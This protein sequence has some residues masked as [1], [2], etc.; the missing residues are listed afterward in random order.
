M[1]SKNIKKTVVLL[2]EFI[3]VFLMI[4]GIFPLEAGLF[5][6]A[7]LIFYFIFSPTEDSVWVFVASLPLFTILAWQ[8]KTVTSWRVLLTIIFFVWLFQKIKAYYKENSPQFGPY[9]F[10]KSHFSKLKSFF[11]EPFIGL[12]LVFLIIGFLSLIN[13]NHLFFGIKKLLFLINTF[14]LFVLIRSLIIK[15]RKFLLKIIQ[16]VR[17]SVIFILGI[18]FIQLFFVFL[19]PLHTFWKFWA[20]KIIP[21]FYG[22]ALGS[23]LSTSNTWFSYYAS[24]PPTLRM[25][26]VF[27]DSHSF[28]LFCVLSLPFFLTPI[29]LRPAKPKKTRVL[30]Y[31]I[32]IIILLAIIFSGSR[33]IWVSAL[34]SLIIFLALILIYFSPTI[35]SKTGFFLP[36]DKNKWWHQIKLI[37]GSLM[38]F[39]LLFP[40]SSGIFFLSQKAQTDGSFEPSG[41]VFERAK[42]IT[43][44]EEISAKSRLQ[45]WRRT[46]DSIL[47][48]P[49]L[50]VGVG[51]YPVVL[52][53]KIEKAE[54]GS[55]AHNLY[56]DIFSE[57]G[58]FGFLVF[59][60]IF[61]IIFK[62]A[63]NL[64]LKGKKN[65][66]K[67]WSG[68][69]VFALIWLLSYSLFD[70]VLLN[71]KVLLFFMLNLGIL[72]AI[73]YQNSLSQIKD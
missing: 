18:G 42:S 49:V 45:I 65:F 38:I 11:S 17:I 10:F 9:N 40:I 59:I 70:V 46:I 30:L 60:I 4:F 6:A 31:S 33:G 16:T 32:L 51:N 44:T 23:L 39:F 52:K 37:I 67:V 63:W 68:F 57:V 34:G 35:K 73:K 13:A 71:D 56:L 66:Y 58:I 47:E 48:K 19:A 12:S 50:G 69:F 72:Y 25:F 8:D 3:F 24:Q 22:E 53:E 41:G 15:N 28:A 5:L 2:T 64:F 43:D 14:F 7:I 1:Q 54:E 21:V 55:S 29:F 20:S 62:D 61:L 26:S 36:S 27:P